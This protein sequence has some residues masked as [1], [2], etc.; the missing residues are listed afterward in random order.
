MAAPCR[1]LMRSTLQGLY[2]VSN[3]TLWIG[4][5][6]EQIVARPRLQENVLHSRA[7]QCGH[8]AL[9]T[10]TKMES[11]KVLKPLK[12]AELEHK[13]NQQKKEEEDE[14]DEDNSP[15]YIPKRKAKNPMMKI[16]YAWMIGLPTGI[17]GFILAKRQVDKNRLKQLKIRQRMKRSNEGDYESNRYKP[18]PRMQ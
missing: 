17:I 16:G 11:H 3:R 13:T 7:L 14:E 1:K 15:E 18:A 9:Q 6:F 8:Y 12:G 2:Q 4:S 5:H 10:V